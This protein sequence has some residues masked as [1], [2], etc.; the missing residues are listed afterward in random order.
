MKP[1]Q[2]IVALDGLERQEAIALAWTLSSHVW[3]FKVNDLL[4]KHGIDIIADL[5]CLGNVFADPKLYDIPNT[6]ANSVRQLA[7]A[8]ADFI[9]V[10]A[11]GGRKMIR[12]ALENAQNAK[13][14]AVTALTSLG[15]ADMQETYCRR[16]DE[17]VWDLAH[18]AYEA[19]AH[20]VVCSSQE[21]A[22]LDHLNF[23]KV[24]PGIRTQPEGDQVRVGDGVGADYIVVGRPVTQARDPLQA[25]NDILKE[26][27]CP[28]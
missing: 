9:T 24:V 27:K 16:T 2:I 4:L 28:R 20:G 7:S 14:L 3:G 15:E 21:V 26:K 12:A 5:K 13:I 6:V 10:H 25:L 23:I 17:L 11:S 8:G 22:L 19:G 1:E 18:L